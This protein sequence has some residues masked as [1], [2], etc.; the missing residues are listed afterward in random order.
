[1][2][3]GKLFGAFRA[4]INKIANLFFEADPIAQMRYEYDLAVQQLK[5]GREGLEQYRGLVEKVSRQVKLGEQQVTRLK[6]QAAAYLK[7]GDRETAGKF[8][9]E[10]R[11]AEAELEE[12]RAQLSLHEQSYQNNLKKIQHA[13][14]QLVTVRE[15][16]T[17][18]DAELK[19]SEAEAEIAKL[20]QSFELDVTT[21]FGQLETVIQERIDKNRGVARVAADLSRNGI[22]EIEAEEK[23]E[24]AMADGA[25]RDLEL[26]LG[27]VTPEVTASPE[28]KKEL[29]PALE[30][31]KS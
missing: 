13:N 3:L 14:K 8:A 17:R 15:K 18:Y 29:G 12:N 16:I 20:S 21:D 31:E 27:L 25:L 28:A 11:R 1:M 22:A 7:A 19:M 6:A 23:M 26:E 9:L 5:E 2:I 4:Q 30:P 24:Q 10:L